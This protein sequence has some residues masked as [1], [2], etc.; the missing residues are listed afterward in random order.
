MVPV[1]V[2]DEPL[3][4]EV[5][6]VDASVVLA[7]PE[8]PQRTDSLD[9]RDES[10]ELILERLVNGAEISFRGDLQLVHPPVAGVHEPALCLAIL[11]EY[12]VQERNIALLVLGIVSKRRVADVG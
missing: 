10:R 5:A 7:E 12:L 4:I 6:R 8:E 9:V 11:R 2:P 3:A 1:V